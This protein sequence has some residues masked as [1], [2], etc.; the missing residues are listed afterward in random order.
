MNQIRIVRLRIEK[1][2]MSHVIELI[3]KEVEK[4]EIS[5]NNIEIFF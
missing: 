4:F 5:E 3:Y 1:I 2:D